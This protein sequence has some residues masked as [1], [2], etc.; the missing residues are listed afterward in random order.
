MST[1]IS[2]LLSTYNGECYL[3]EQIQSIIQQNY[4]YWKL[5]IRDD[6]STDS[7]KDI[8]LRFCEIYPNIYFLEDNNTKLG[9]ALSFMYLLER[10]D[11]DY[12]MFCDQDDIWFHNKISSVIHL[13]QKNNNV[14]SL[15]FSDAKIV[16]QNLNIIHNSFWEY[17]KLSPKLILSN[18]KFIAVCNCAPGCTMIFNKALKKHLVDYE[19]SILM[20]DWYVMVKAL[21]YGTV[22]YCDIPLMMYRQHQN[23]VLGAKKISIFNKLRNILNFKKT[24]RDQIILL[25]FIKKY[26]HI[27]YLTFYL[28]KI[29][30]NFLRFKK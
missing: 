23:N 11:S 27:D 20:H 12:Y 9:A 29:K 10:V 7:T 30:F 21:E 26:I 24:I 14:P 6:G 3:E 22:N 16:D 28:L 17:N 2:I 13:L 15:V 4:Q 25:K 18:P 8:I 1:T 5:Y 19:K